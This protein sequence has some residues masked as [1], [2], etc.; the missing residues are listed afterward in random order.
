MKESPFVYAAIVFSMLSRTTFMVLLYRNR[1]TRLLSCVVCCLNVLSNSFWIPYA[2]SIDSRP[3]LIR[4]GTDG[5]LSLWGMIYIL[6]N[7]SHPRPVEVDTG[8]R[9]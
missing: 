8:V 9:H 1:S 5:I 2:W 6:Y 7:R 4:S 3:L